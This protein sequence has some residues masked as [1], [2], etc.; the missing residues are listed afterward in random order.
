VIL[1]AAEAAQVRDTLSALDPSALPGYP[2]NTVILMRAVYLL[3]LE[4]YGEAGKEL[5]AA[6]AADTD[7]PS[8]HL[9]LGHVHERVGLMELAAGEF[10]EAQFLLSSPGRREKP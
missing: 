10:D 7:E 2:R 9:M 1:P 5:Q 3:E 6:I 4:L 8:L